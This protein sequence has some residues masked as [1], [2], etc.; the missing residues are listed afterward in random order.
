MTE[1]KPLISHVSVKR[2]EDETRVVVPEPPS[3]VRRAVAIA[4]CFELPQPYV[5][6]DDGQEQ[7]QDGQ[8][9]DHLQPDPRVLAKHGGIEPVDHRTHPVQDPLSE[10]RHLD[11]LPGGTGNV[12]FSA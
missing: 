10:G 9:D 1:N 6:A 8:P 3:E 12:E 4:P 7:A 2:P 11:N 5:D